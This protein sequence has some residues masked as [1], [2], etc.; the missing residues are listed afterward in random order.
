[1]NEQI[2]ARKVR[3]INHENENVGIVSLREALQLAEE[4]E[5]DLVEVAPN[6]DP[7]VVRVMDYGKFLYDKQK[8]DKAARNQQKQIEIKEIRLRPKTDS[9]HLGF[10]L[11]DAIKWLDQGMKVR[12]RVRF[13]G[14]EIQYPELAEE[15]LN[16]VVKHLED[17]AQVESPPKMD[18]RTM[19]LVLAP[20]DKKKKKS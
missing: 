17:V 5:L 20:L 2:R 15:M 16:D 13:R 1:V 3:L 4:H 10:K 18:G 19:L 7:P 6:A 11:R 9:H 12:V 8:R 14:R